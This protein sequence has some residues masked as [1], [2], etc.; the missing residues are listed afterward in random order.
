MNKS[1]IKFIT[2]FGPLLIFLF[3]TKNMEW[4]EAILPLII[5]TAISIL[6]I[7]LTEKR[8]PAMPPDRSNISRWFWR[9]Y[10]ILQ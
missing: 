9:P 5:A 6:V 4:K 1:L 2:D 7:Y 8:I 10:F 3:F